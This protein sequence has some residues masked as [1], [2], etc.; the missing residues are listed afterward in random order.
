MINEHL[1]DNTSPAFKKAV[2]H[3]LIEVEKVNSLGNQ[4]I[5]FDINKKTVMDIE[6]SPFNAEKEQYINLELRISNDNERDVFYVS[7]SYLTG[8]TNYDDHE[9]GMIAVS[10]ESHFGLISYGLFPREQVDI[11]KDFFLKHLNYVALKEKTIPLK[12]KLS[13]LSN[14][15]SLLDEFPLFQDKENTEEPT[16]LDLKQGFLK[17]GYFYMDLSDEP[18]LEQPLQI[19]GKEGFLDTSKEPNLGMNSQYE[20]G[21]DNIKDRSVYDSMI[22][23]KRGEK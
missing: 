12:R 3:I 8:T 18:E 11:A 5:R 2:N 7:F 21:L 16:A 20:Q 4:K 10:A 13:S 1:L 14:N 6:D 15:N 23:N 19:L 17:T 9:E 22:E